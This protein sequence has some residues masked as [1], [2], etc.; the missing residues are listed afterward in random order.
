MTFVERSSYLSV[1]GLE[2]VFAYPADLRSQLLWMLEEMKLTR[3]GHLPGIIA[4]ALIVR[5]RLLGSS[6]DLREGLQ[7]TRLDG[8]GDLL[9]LLLG[10][11]HGTQTHRLLIN[12]AFFT[13]DHKV[14]R[15][16]AAQANLLHQ[17]GFSV[18]RPKHTLKGKRDE[19]AYQKAKK[20]LI[21][22]KKKR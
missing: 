15:P 14:A 9:Q 10:S 1:I 17:E 11:L 4:T 8:F 3:S 19:K 7:P 18:H 16:S 13:V 2:D 22:L 5:N 21:C 6:A 12:L 20:D